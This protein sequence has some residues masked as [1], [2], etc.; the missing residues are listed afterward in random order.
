MA[1]GGFDAL[2]DSL[3]VGYKPQVVEAMVNEETPFRSELSKE[4][5]SG[6]KVTEG[7][8]RFAA[9][10]N[11]PQNWGQ[12][13]DIGTLPTA[14]DRTEVLLKIAPTIF[15]GSLQLGM[16]TRYAA[17]SGKSAFNGGEVRRKSDEAMVDLAK[18]IET[19]YIGTAGL[20][21]RGQVESA[22]SNSTDFVGAKP[23]GTRLLRENMYIS[24]RAAA[25][26]TAA[27]VTTEGEFVKISSITHS[28]RT[29]TLAS[30]STITASYYVHAVTEYQQAFTGGTVDGVTYALFANGIRGLVDDGTYLT[31]VHALA[32]SSYPKLNAQVFGNSGTLRNLTEQLLIRACHE[33]RSRSGKMPT[34]A[35]MGEGQAEK[36]VEFVAPDRR[37]PRSGK[38]DTGNMV[39]GYREGDL[40]HVGPGINLTLKTSFDI[41]ARELYLLHW[42]SFFRY[43]SKPLGVLDEGGALKLIPVAGGFRAGYLGYVAAIENLGCENFQAQGV[44][45]DLNDPAIGD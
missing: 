2:G 20:G 23:W 32:R 7:A 34:A 25:G 15:A 17:N 45:R 37:L 10:L 13:L 42:P 9:N 27:A 26:G 41:V 12:I 8:V 1:A 3:K 28:T 44:I 5:P 18:G 39:T 11:P 14:K 24:P 29:V 35:W 4:L 6:S 40:V 33:I 38:S 22:T 16:M 30:A 43:E 21:A 19:T 36:Y 31:T